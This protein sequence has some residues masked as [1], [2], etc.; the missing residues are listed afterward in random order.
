MPTSLQRPVSN[1]TSQIKFLYL[2]GGPCSELTESRTL[3]GPEEV[4]SVFLTLML[5]AHRQ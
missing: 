5:E 4:D 1:T 2:L 3:V